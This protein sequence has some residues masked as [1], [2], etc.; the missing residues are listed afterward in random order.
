ML[1]KLKMKTFLKDKIKCE[2]ELS[3]L[4][5]RYLLTFISFNYMH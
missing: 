5:S 2:Q 3:L 4:N 1:V